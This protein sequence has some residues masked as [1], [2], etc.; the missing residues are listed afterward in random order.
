MEHHCIGV[1]QSPITLKLENVAYLL[2]KSSTSCL[3]LMAKLEIVVC[4][5]KFVGTALVPTKLVGT[6]CGNSCSNK[7]V[8]T[9]YLLLKQY[10][11]VTKEN[12][13]AA[14]RT[15]TQSALL[16][17]TACG[18]RSSYK[19]VRTDYLLLKQYRGDPIEKCQGREADRH[20]KCTTIWW[21][22]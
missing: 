7:F 3:M 17:G 4:S 16:Y 9:D 13:W 18:N 2:K 11:G 15:A 5:D 19:F 21:F 12:R 10:R 22:H 8:G 20:T 1:S 14:K 6:A